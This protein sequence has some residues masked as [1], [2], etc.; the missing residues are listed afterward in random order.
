MRKIIFAIAIGVAGLL[1]GCAAEVYPDAGPYGYSTVYV[2]P[3]H[4]H[5]H[6]YHARG[7]DHH[8]RHF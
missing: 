8:H 3:G 6:H 7:W 1:G 4:Y 2:A 5:H